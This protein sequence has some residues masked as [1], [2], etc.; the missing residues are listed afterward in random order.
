MV[1]VQSV[2]RSPIPVVVS[3][4]VEDAAALRSTRTH[5]VSAPHVKLLHLG[6]LDERLAAH[7]DGVAVAGDF[8][9]QLAAAALESP[10]TGQV[11]V[12]TVRA[13]QTGQAAGLDKLFSLVEAV[14]DAQKGLTSAFG[15]VSAETLQ[16]TGS[17]LLN[18]A[19][20]FRKRVGITA[21]ALHRV[22][23]SAALNAAMSSPDAPLRARS[24]RCAGEVGRR[25]QLPACVEHLN[26]EDPVCAFWAAWSAILFGDRR[27]SLDSLRALGMSPS[28]HRE[29]ALQLV[30]K[31]LGNQDAH[32]LLKA[33]AP[34]PA[35]QRVLIQATGIVGDPFYVPWLIK[36]MA[37]DK[38][39]RLAGESFSLITGLD[40]AYLDLERKPP[41]GLELGPTDNPDDEDVAMD[42]DDS[43]PWPDPA[44]IQKWWDAN[45]QRFQPGVR[46]FMGEP[47]NIENCKHVLRD[48]YQRQRI[49]AALYLSLLQPGTPLFPTSAPAWRQQRWLAKMG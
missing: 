45:K 17:A 49:A 39:M 12:A 11:F 29:R 41:E 26:D 33:L 35:N 3:Q 44:K 40:L 28:P 30:L 5:L 21:C 47:V 16:G 8:G 34:D 9:A 46:Y 43:L 2:A 1:N 23:P 36:Q 18:A 42:A 19:A 38:T 48:G 4:H 10:G 15:W 24:L 20:P 31:I 13:I 37:G 7:L 25:D 32:P 22:D 27:R 14:P 6:R